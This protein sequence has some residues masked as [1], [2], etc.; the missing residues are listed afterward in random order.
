M[1]VGF[2][3]LGIMGSRMA[4]H[5]LEAGH[6][7]IVNNR[8]KDKAEALIEAGA[9]WAGSPAELAGMD[10]DVLMTI[11]STPEVV[12]SVALDEGGFLDALKPGTLWIESSTTNPTFARRMAAEAQARGIRFMDAPVAG[13]KNQAA[14]S[15]LVFMVGG[16]DADVAQVQ[17]LFDVM[18]KET[19]HVGGAGMGIS[20]KIVVNHMLGVGMVAFAEGAILAQ[21]LGISEQKV[22]DTL[23]G[24]P[25]TPPFVAGKRA[26]L[27]QGEYSPEFPLQWLQKDLHMTDQAAYEVGLALPA[28]NAAKD[29]F[30]LAIAAGYGEDDFTA[31]YEFLAK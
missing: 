2:I 27:E 28:N 12:E 29:L 26:K 20:L 6:E 1:K 17:P 30:Q 8:S 11:L 5:I 15:E 14:A 18:G 4:A 7:L 16:D 19:N 23:I 22:F 9:G 24:G 3:G 31:L 25:V 21:R 10:L 13:S